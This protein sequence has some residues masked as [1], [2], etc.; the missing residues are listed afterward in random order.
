M[1]SLATTGLVTKSAAPRRKTRSR[2]EISLSAVITNGSGVVGLELFGS[3]TQ[4]SGIL[5][6]DDTASTLYYPHIASDEEWWTGVV[7]FNPSSSSST[8]TITPYTEEGTSLDTREHVITPGGKYIGTVDGLELPPDT[9]WFT[10][11]SSRAI[12]GFELFGKDDGSQLAGYTGVGIS[13]KEGVFAKVEKNGWTGIAFVNIE[14]AAAS[15][16]LTAY[17]NYGTEVATRILSLGSHAKLVQLAQEIFNQD[18]S[19]ATYIEYS[20]SK[21]LVGF[22]LNGS[23]NGMMLDALPGM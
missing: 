4:L 19:A 13:G 18:I 5:L 3:S 20:S 10:I 23:S 2:V 21:E 9:A 7:A 6:K 12:T 14:D 17:D 11:D 22:Q 1:K 8:I 15:V 16:T